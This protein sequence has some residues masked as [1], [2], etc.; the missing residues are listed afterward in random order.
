MWQE[1]SAGV[2][3]GP[4]VALAAADGQ[5]AG[6]PLLLVLRQRALEGWALP[7]AGD[8]AVQPLWEALLAEVS[9]AGAAFP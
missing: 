9:R 8:G 1:L 4:A 6:P 5:G 3:Q 2:A 7:P